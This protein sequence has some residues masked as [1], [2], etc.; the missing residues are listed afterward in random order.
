M[1]RNEAMPYRSTWLLV[2][3]GFVG[4]IIVFMVAGVSIWPAFL[5]PVTY[6]L[7]FYANSRL[8]G[9]SGGY[10]RGMEHAN[11]V[12][13]LLVWPTNPPEYTREFM[14]VAPFTRNTVC[15]S[16]RDGG[17]VHACIPHTRGC[18]D[19][20]VFLPILIRNP[21]GIVSKYQTLSIS[22]G[23]SRNSNAPG[24]KVYRKIL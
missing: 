19:G 24:I 6:F 4:T 1:E 12:H 13:R 15:S 16:E 3:F 21:G 5:M 22:S 17:L 14:I 23:L 8:Y 20:H 11:A 10:M 2:V 7:Y 9:L 18:R